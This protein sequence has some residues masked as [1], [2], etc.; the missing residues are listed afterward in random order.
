MFKGLKQ[1]SLTMANNIFETYQIEESTGIYHKVKARFSKKILADLLPSIK[2]GD[3]VIEIGP[4][5]GHFAFE[6][7]KK[8]I[9]YLGLE[10]SKFLRKELRTK[11]INLLAAFVPPIPLRDKSCDL[12]YACTMMEHLPTHVEAVQFVVEIGRVLKDE[13]YLCIVVP[14]YNTLKNLFFDLDYSHSYIT[15][16]RRITKL[17]QDNGFQ[18]VE[19]QHVI[20]FF[21]VRTTFLFNVIRHTVNILMIPFHWA[22]TTWIFEYLGLERL[23]WMIRKTFYEHLIIVSKK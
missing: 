21:W 13:K 1:V 11:G 7:Q 20:G 19:R 16:K 22:L 17:L 18:I 5:Q 8:N 4:G 3:R 9:N 6:C 12:V 10:P 15:T 2:A 14:N 23:L